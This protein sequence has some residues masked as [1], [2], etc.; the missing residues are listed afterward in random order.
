VTIDARGKGSTRDNLAGSAGAATASPRARVLADQLRASTAAL[1]GVIERIPPER[2]HHVRKPGEWSPGKDAE[3]AAD[4]AALHL[5]H[6]RWS[7]NVDGPGPPVIDRA[8]L[9]AVRSQAEIARVLLD[10]AERGAR[11]IEGLTD[12]QLDLPAQPP[13]R[14]MR[15]VAD[16]I[17]RPLI[18]HLGTHEEQIELK[19]R[20]VQ[21]S[22]KQRIARLHS[23]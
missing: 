3:H 6:V 15:T 23:G 7:L 22:G 4:A 19:L 5:W 20:A 16:I 10:C 1:I 14:P 21:P 2:W 18:R 12:A 17:A 11:L 13:R 8:R 9:Q